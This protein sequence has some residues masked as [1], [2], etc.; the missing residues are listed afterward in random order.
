M[1]SHCTGHSG[2]PPKDGQGGQNEGRTGQ[3]SLLHGAKGAAKRFL[4]DTSSL[5][6][7]G[8]CLWYKLCMKFHAAI[9]VG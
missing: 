5:L 1:P 9:P 4:P 3:E 7:F 8:A 2:E 6:A